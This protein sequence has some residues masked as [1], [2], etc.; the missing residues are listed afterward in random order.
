MTEGSLGMFLLLYGR[1]ADLN[2]HV[3]GTGNGKRETGNGEF[4][5]GGISKFFF[6]L[7]TPDITLM[8]E[9]LKG[10]ISKRGNL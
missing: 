10:E 2:G 9:S 7:L 5:K 1:R 3:L 8:G 4:L 6:I